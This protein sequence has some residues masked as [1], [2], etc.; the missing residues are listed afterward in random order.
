LSKILNP[1]F[2]K[3]DGPSLDAKCDILE[4]TSFPVNAINSP[5]SNYTWRKLCFLPIEWY[6]EWYVFLNELPTLDALG[7]IAVWKTS[8]S[9][10]IRIQHNHTSILTWF[11][12][13]KWHLVSWRIWRWVIHLDFERYGIS[14]R[15]VGG[16]NRIVYKKGKCFQTPPSQLF[17]NPMKRTPAIQKTFYGWKVIFFNRVMHRKWKDNAM[18]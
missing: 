2:L 6:Q 16:W 10:H 11:D 13:N 7:S 14:L 9:L 15:R 1:A 17:S 12:R 18:I 4:D 8:Y 5:T 3:M